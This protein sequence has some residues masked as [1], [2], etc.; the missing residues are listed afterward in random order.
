MIRLIGIAVCVL[1]C[2]ILVRDKNRSAAA[3]LSIAGGAVLLTG[4]AGELYKIAD[5]LKS[6]SDIYSASRS[7]IKLM[8]KVLGITVLTG[9]ISDICRDNGENALASAAEI[10][11]KI[12]TV[13]MLLPLF[14][15]AVKIIT[16]L[17][18]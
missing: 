12:I 11:A 16:G 5:E 2:R 15:T 8:L 1:F 7:Y 4:A 9:F 13:A 17:I 6:L 18:G 10:C 14:E 3:V